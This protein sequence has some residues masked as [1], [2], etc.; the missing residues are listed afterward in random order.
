[1]MPCQR[2]FYNVIRFVELHAA[3][4][5]IWQWMILH[6]YMLAR[7][8]LAI[9]DMKFLS[10]LHIH[11]LYL[12]VPRHGRCG[13]QCQQWHRWRRRALAPSVALCSLGQGR[14]K[15]FSWRCGLAKYFKINFELNLTHS[16]SMCNILMTLSTLS[17]QWYFV[18]VI[19]S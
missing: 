3:L 8:H 11:D 5:L 10:S 19:I 15:G 1:M 13:G 12:L 4:A 17:T 16:I 9:V 6:F 7:L 2:D 18:N 14:V